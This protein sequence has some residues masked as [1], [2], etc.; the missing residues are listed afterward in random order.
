MA[1]LVSLSV[2]AGYS[3]S[4]GA[5]FFFKAEVFYEALGMLL[6]FILAGHWLEMRAQSGA[7]K[8]VKALLNLAPPKAT[9]IRN[10]QPVEVPTAEVLMN[11][12]LLR[13][14][15]RLIQRS[16]DEK[17]NVPIGRLAR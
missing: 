5:T 13:M 12:D 3:F 7:S 17:A 14:K 8:A 10:G 9:V 1:V 15:A 6:V 11:D 4:V 16:E 2:L